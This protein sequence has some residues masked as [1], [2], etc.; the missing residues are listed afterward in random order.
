MLLGQDVFFLLGSE[1][2]LHLYLIG[3]ESA[4]RRALEHSELLQGGGHSGRLR[5]VGLSGRLQV[6]G[7]SVHLQAAGLSDP[8][9]AAGHPVRPQAAERV[10]M[11]KDGEDKRP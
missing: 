2:D 1:T 3:T 4:R 8:P 11:T 6:A 7:R 9:R 10:L 5:A